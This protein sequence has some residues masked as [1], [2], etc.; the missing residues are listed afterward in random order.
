MPASLASPVASKR[1]VLIVNTHARKGQKAL[2]AARAALERRGHHV[3][4]PPILHAEDIGA[5]IRASRGEADVVVVG[6]GDGTLVCALPAIR[7]LGLPLAILPLGT[8]NELAR[9]LAIPFALD[10]ACALIDTGR[11]RQIDAACANDVWYFNEAS[12]GLS[13]HVARLQTGEMKSRW[14]MLSIPIATLR[15]WRSLRPYHLTV[16]SEHGT[17]HFRTVQLTIANS[18]RFGGVA[19]NP[20]AAID[21]G[22]LDLYSIEIS[23][24]LDVLHVLRAVLRRRFPEARNVTTLRAPSFTVR[25]VRPHHVAADGERATMT[26]APFRVERNAVRVIVPA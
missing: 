8:T 25:G 18:Y 21:D 26:P 11:E 24:L 4:V 9:T 14:G 22:M 10:A 19:E 16:E 1:V 15:A 12:I 6:G 2:D 13:T 7:E 17:Q 20:D 23:S 3:V 5:A